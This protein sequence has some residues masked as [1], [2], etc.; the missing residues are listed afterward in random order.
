MNNKETFRNNYYQSLK[1]IWMASQVVEYKLC[2][3]RFD[4]EHCQFDKVMRNLLCDNS[5]ETYDISNIIDVIAQNLT[6]IK[7]DD[8]IIYLKNNLLT[9]QICPNTFYLGLNPIFSSFLDN[10]DSITITEHKKNINS[11]ENIIQIC[12]EWGSVSI[13]SPMNFLIH[14]IPGDPKK[15]IFNSQWLAII[16]TS[17]QEISKGRLHQQEWKELYSCATNIIDEIKSHIPQVGNTMMDG[18]TKIKFLHQIV[19][20]SRYLSILNS[21]ISL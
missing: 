17:N 18:G 6:R 16:G 8:Q 2:D 4:C 12:G 7:F 10:I 19:G 1:C 9:K 15:D 3:N 14:D 13:S 20:K 21:L 11:G 5:T